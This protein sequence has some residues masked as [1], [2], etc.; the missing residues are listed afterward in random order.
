MPLALVLLALLGTSCSR[1]AKPG[2]E[3]A[4]PASTAAAA[5]TA[6]VATNPVGSVTSRAD[7]SGPQP[8]CAQLAPLGPAAVES[9]SYTADLDADGLSDRVSSYAVGPAPAPGDWHLRVSFGAGGGSDL[10]VA[11]NPAPGRVAVLGSAAL[12]PQA[13]PGPGE[14]RP[15]LFVWTGSGASSR[16]IGLYR[17]DGCDLVALLSAEGGPVGFV[18]GASLGHQEGLRCAVVDGQHVVIEILSQASPVSGYEVT[19]RAYGGAGN[20]L[21]VQ[22]AAVQTTSAGPPPEGG[23]IVGCGDVQPKG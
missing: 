4:S 23:Q 17:V 5:S 10:V 12:G 2:V 20:E 18:V 19:T 15:A 6:V 7:T 22:G 9:S 16:S 14:G 3:Q 11:D 1:V 21:S 8:D 13:Q